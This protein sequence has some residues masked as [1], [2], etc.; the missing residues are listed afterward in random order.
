MWCTKNR[1]RV[2]QTQDL[3]SVRQ[4]LCCPEK[5]EIWLNCLICHNKQWFKKNKIH[6]VWCI[7]FQEMNK[8]M[9]NIPI[10]RNRRRK[11]WI[12][13][14]ILIGSKIEWVIKILNFISNLGNKQT[15]Q[16]IQ[17]KPQPP[18]YTKE[19]LNEWIMKIMISCS[20]VYHKHVSLNQTHMLWV[21]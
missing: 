3:C 1:I 15:N 19:L 2:V 14:G 8:N 6:I 4:P 16:R 13:P 17:E 9:E 21:F 10:L 20:T 11:F 7:T 12:C 18:L 5:K